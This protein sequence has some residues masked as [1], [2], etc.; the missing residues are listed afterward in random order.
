MNGAVVRNLVRAARSLHPVTLLARLDGL[1]LQNELT[2]RR[3][4]NTSTGRT[5]TKEN[6]RGGPKLFFLLFRNIYF[7]STIKNQAGSLIDKSSI[8]N[9]VSWVRERG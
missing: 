1:E 8:N 9:S 7:I 5:H 4:T 6:I 2:G 3:R